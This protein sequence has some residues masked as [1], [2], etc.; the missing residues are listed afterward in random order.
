MD[1]SETNRWSGAF[2]ELSSDDQ[3]L[4][5]R[6]VKQGGA[7][8]GSEKDI[9]KRLKRTRYLV[10]L[11]IK[12]DNRIVGVAALKTPTGDYRKNKFDAAGVPIANYANA[13]ELGYVVVA[14]EMRGQKLSGNLCNAIT[15]VISEPA[16]ATTDSNTMKHNLERA[17]FTKAGREWQGRKGMLS[18]WTIT[19]R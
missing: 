18:L 7:I 10:L 13:L 19:P 16:F 12:A 1:T 14:E 15:Q 5:A 11:R 8:D 6:L 9:T 2:G 3:L 17:G 4:V